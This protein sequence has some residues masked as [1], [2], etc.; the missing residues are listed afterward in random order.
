MWTL[1]Y[2]IP[3]SILGLPTLSFVRNA[4]LTV[5]ALIYGPGTSVSLLTPGFSC[6]VREPYP[7]TQGK[8]HPPRIFCV[9]RS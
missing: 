1:L 7:V 2:P 3:D 5:A 4:R 9:S 6:E 8:S